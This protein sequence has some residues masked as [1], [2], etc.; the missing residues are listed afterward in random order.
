MFLSVNNVALAWLP[1]TWQETGT[2]W[3][4]G[5][6]GKLGPRGAGTD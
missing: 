5:R 2:M 6:I 1:S 4:G 3:F